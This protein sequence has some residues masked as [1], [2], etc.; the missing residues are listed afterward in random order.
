MTF[1]CPA[2]LT[3]VHI[4]PECMPL[5]VILPTSDLVYLTYATVIS[6]QQPPCSV[7]VT[8]VHT[9]SLSRLRYCCSCYS[10]LHGRKGCWLDTSSTSRQPT[11]LHPRPLSSQFTPLPSLHTAISWHPMNTLQAQRSQHHKPFVSQSLG[12]TAQYPTTV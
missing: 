3:A 5:A 8:D 12:S 4:P 11:V 7:H 1:T 9:T 10:C 2:Q 6:P